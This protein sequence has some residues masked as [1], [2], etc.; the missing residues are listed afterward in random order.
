[1]VIA[2]FGESC[3]GKSTLANA[4]AL[5]INSTIFTGK[6]YLRLA[7]S[8]SEAIRLFKEKLQNTVTDDIIYV[9]TEKQHLDLLPQNAMR[10]LLTAPLEVIKQR[11]ACRMRGILPPP[12]AQ[13]LE[14]NHG[15]FDDQPCHIHLESGFDV[16]DTVQ[17]IVSL[18]NDL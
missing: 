9:I 13:M 2:I 18:S 17:Q 14:R 3:T 8:E 10:V 4:L 15:I 16:D 7:K 5:H 11:F 6:D 12:V 1:M